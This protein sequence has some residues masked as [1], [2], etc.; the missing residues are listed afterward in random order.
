[1]K[2]K[3][4]I[5]HV[6]SIF[7]TNF[8]SGARFK[9]DEVLMVKAEPNYKILKYLPTVED[10][11][12][13]AKFC[14]LKGSICIKNRITPKLQYVDRLPLFCQAHLWWEVVVSVTW[15]YV[16]VF[17]CPSR[18]L[19]MDTFISIYE[20]QNSLAQLFS[21]IS[22]SAIW[23]FHSGRSKVKVRWAGWVWTLPSNKIC[24]DRNS[25]FKYG[26]QTN[27]TLIPT[28]KDPKEGRLWKVLWGKEKNAGYQQFLHFPQCFLL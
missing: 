23:K 25:I 2:H 11:E 1:M 18:F 16:R 21:W 24:P 17:I 4:F 26:F 14:E 6:G 13:F 20:F 9:G 19:R 22:R 28:F 8:Q 3:N 27:L 15:M 12:K 7:F 10:R 5:G